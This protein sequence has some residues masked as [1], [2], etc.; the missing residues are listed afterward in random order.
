MT[1]LPPLTALRAFEAAARTNSF[2]LAAEALCVTTGAVS[3]QVRLLEAHLG[4]QLFARSH[5]RVVLTAAGQRYAAAV[6]QTFDALAEAGEALGSGG[7]GALVRLDCVPTLSMHWL[8]PRLA[9]LLEDRGDIRIDTSTGL[10]PVDPAAP[11][12]IAIRR[13][14]RHFVGLTASVLMTEWS[15][16]LCSPAFAKTH[17][18]TTPETVARAP[19]IHIRAREDLWPTWT[20]RYGLAATAA[21]RRLTLDHTFAALQAAED[22]L[23]TVVMPVLFA[24]KQLASGRLIAPLP[25]TLADSGEYFVVTRTDD[26]GAAV[27]DVKAWLLEQ[28]RQSRNR[29]LPESCRVQS[30]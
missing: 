3:R 28:G 15:T 16:P 10:G 25:Q 26:E 4:V 5:R 12:D 2:T 27:A 17:G 24:H 6:R 18:L 14:P 11:F 23:G 20:R 29:W 8:T 7:A 22:G 1:R 13:D 21:A 9:A 30:A 19:T